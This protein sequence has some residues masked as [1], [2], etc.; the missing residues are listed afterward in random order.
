MAVNK[1]E[2]DK[3]KSE[4]FSTLLYHV[5]RY[6][7]G[8]L[9]RAGASLG[10]TAIFTRIFLPAKFGY[11]NLVR[12]IVLFVTLMLT[13]WM[14]QAINRYLPSLE[15]LNEKRIAK[16]TIVL[17][18]LLFTIFLLILNI[19]ILF[20]KPYFGIWFNKLCFATVSLIWG[21]SIYKV[22]LQVLSAEIKSNYHTLI[23]TLRSMGRL[24]LPLILV[25]LISKKV[26][27]LVWGEAIGTFLIIPFMWKLADLELSITY[28]IKHIKIIKT[29]IIKYFK[30]GS[31]MIGWFL[32]YILLAIGD[33][34]IIQI[35]RGAKEVGIY[36]ANYSLIAGGTE[37][38]AAPFL[39]IAHPYLVKMWNQKSKEE[40]QQ[41][42]SDTT[43]WFIYMASVLI[44][45][46]MFLSKPITNIL[47]GVK[48]R[49]GYWVIPI[50]GTGLLIWHLSMYGHKPLEFEEDTKRM[51]LGGLGVA[52][53]NVMLNIILVPH[54]GY[55]AAAYTTLI[56]YLSYA[57]LIYFS[58]KKYMDW[59]IPFRQV[60]R[61]IIWVL[62]GG[63]IA[64]VFLREF[65]NL[66]FFSKH[67]IAIFI[68]GVIAVIVPLRQ[69]GINLK[70][71]LNKFKEAL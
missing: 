67:I 28:I 40:V 31:P 30:Y 65:K 14:K 54:F 23:K 33:R 59:I 25:F 18:I 29:N 48:Y 51:M 44:I 56:S 61:K 5:L 68:Y 37:L 46:L 35:F 62:V 70:Q 7:I 12:S 22:C 21:L 2:K 19:I 24:F 38:V 39:L 20:I 6:G 9:T 55:M 41:L 66:G 47:L 45:A 64:T 34:Y 10:F 50:A 4:H 43:N 53:L 3:D 60:F 15:D 36:S 26:E 27:Y 16:N 71:V 49:V 63:L 58:V 69:E 17:Y 32:A 11:Y 42:I 52:A 8:G 57:V 1:I 13:E